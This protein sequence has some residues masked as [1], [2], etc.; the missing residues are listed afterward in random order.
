MNYTVE[1]INVTSEKVI[2]PRP[3]SK[4]NEA[5]SY[6]WWKAQ[7]EQDLIAQLLSTTEFLKRTSATRIKQASI[8]SRLYSGKPVSNFLSSNS[9]LDSSN[10]LPIGRPTA[11]VSYSCV[12]TLVSLLSQDRPAP[13][14]LTDGG[15][16]KER[17]AAKTVNQFILGEF[18]RTHAYAMS[19]RQ[20]CDSFV[21]GDG[22]IKVLTKD[23]K[24]H[25]ERTLPT[26]L[27]KDFNDW[28][29]GKGQQLIQLK[30]VDR[31]VMMELFPDREDII[32]GAANGN[33]DSTPRSTDTISDQFIIA[34]G[35]HLKSSE[36]SNDG[37]HSIVC[38]NGVIYD[39]EN[40]D[41]KDFP[42]VNLGFT[43]HVVGPFSQGLIELLMPCQMEIYRNLIINSQS[44][45]LMGVPRI[46]IDELSKIM[47]TSFNN[48][49]GTIIKGRGTA[50]EFI[51]PDVGLGDKI[52]LYVQWLIQNSYEMSGISS[53]SAQAK[54]TPGL[55]SGE[56]IREANDLQSA[57][58]AN[59]E[60]KYQDN[61]IKLAYKM[62][63]QA[64][65]IA[66]EYGSY[67]TV[68][69]GRD[70]TR[71]IDFKEIKHLLEDTYIIQCYNESSLPK[72]PEGRQ[73]RLSEMLAAGEI[74]LQEFRRQSSF[75][76]LEQSDQLASAL[77]ERILHAL[78]EIVDNGDKNYADIAPDPFILDPSDL[79]TTLSVNYINLYATLQLEEEKMQVLK[80]W[81]TQVQG[82]KAQANPPPPPSEAS[83]QGIALPVAPP[84]Q[85]IAPTSNVQV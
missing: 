26:E 28:Y 29:Y 80:D 21:L 10:Q 40:W 49:I 78:D 53:M 43:E 58:F 66:E 14:F 56:A 63:D 27:L 46:Y 33:V 4:K 72:D 81:Y 39:D 9:S 52:L 75:P 83:P 7:T 47:E 57:R 71:T 11:N 18:F 25:L 42:F 12:D 50:P 61:F 24:V 59:L 77:E 1:P 36:D 37:R 34:E 84:Q 30:L 5:T 23:K 82:L 16:Y 74:T 48:R 45:E 60:R 73:A 85:S 79:A 8:F 22:L 54:K 76:D 3:K 65:D 2:D 6:Q 69:P 51:S 20:L 64:K 68:Y 41:K 19:S 32:A 31:S 35:W 44:I 55:N 70:G 17:K 13:T 67:S 62:I 38:S 15:H